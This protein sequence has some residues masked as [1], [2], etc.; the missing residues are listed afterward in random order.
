MR[1]ALCTLAALGLCLGALAQDMGG[2]KGAPP[3]KKEG[4]PC[5]L[6]VLAKSGTCEE[7]KHLCGGDNCDRNK[8]GTCSKCKKKSK[9]C[10]ICIKMLYTCATCGKQAHEQA[11]CCGHGTKGTKVRARIIFKC[12]GCGAVAEKEGDCDKEDCK[13]AGKKIK[14]TC[15]ESGKFPHGGEPAAGT[16]PPPK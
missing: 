16:A 11:K 5:D 8:D 4:K 15:D 14:K 3:A 12:E 10:D 1:L 2:D 9:E 6:K 7:C 13:K